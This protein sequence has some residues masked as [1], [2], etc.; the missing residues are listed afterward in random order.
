MERV[1]SLA[2]KSDGTIIK[3][4]LGRGRPVT[5]SASKLKPAGVPE[6]I[7]AV[8]KPSTRKKP[9]LQAKPLFEHA[10]ALTISDV[11]AQCISHI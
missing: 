4:N 9:K 2:F 5:A 7:A 3:L 1:P 10:P 8:S 6:T 11:N